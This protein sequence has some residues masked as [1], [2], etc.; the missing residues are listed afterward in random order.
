MDTGTYV[1]LAG[2]PRVRELTGVRALEPS[3]RCRASGRSE[4]VEAGWDPR[5]DPQDRRSCPTPRQG[6]PSG[7]CPSD[8]FRTRPGQ[9]RPGS[10]GSRRPQS[11]TSPPQKH[12]CT[13]G[14]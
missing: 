7:N 6:A 1:C 10:M 14:R 2:V 8:V 9:G 13:G 12:R 3:P 5:W 11:A 4:R